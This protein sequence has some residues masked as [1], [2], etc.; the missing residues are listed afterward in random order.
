M[1]PPYP[2]AL[3]PLL[4]QFLQ[5]RN[6]KADFP[7]RAMERCGIDRPAFIFVRD[8]ALASPDGAR[9]NELGNS[10]YAT[11]DEPIRAAAAVARDAGLVEQQGP[12]WTLTAKGRAL[13]EELQ[14]AVA[15]H[16]ASLAPIANDELQN[17]AGLLDRAFHACASAADP[18][19]RGH[20]PRALR[21]RWR[22][23]SSPF[24]LL[25]AAVYGLWQA[26]DDCH[27]QAWT[28]RGLEGPLIDVMTRV[29][30]R[31]AATADELAA[32]IT[33]Q[34]REDVLDGIGRLRSASFMRADEPLA[35]T[36]EGAVLRERIEADT[37]RLFF[38][39]WP[40]D[41]GA[42]AGWLI[43]RLS[44]VNAALD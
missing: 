13:T 6:A 21:Y 16:H 26:R 20:T 33:A 28:D 40:D 18:A 2:V 31:E 19:I 3:V 38:E 4:P 41:V 17:L 29:W 35:L 23:P 39:P 11:T 14:A 32:K 34:P 37:D 30:R 8:L 7:L 24:A 27:V 36:T 10:A 9:L 22:P 25:D 42:Q 5:R 44:A 1:R 15:A 43:D 12:R